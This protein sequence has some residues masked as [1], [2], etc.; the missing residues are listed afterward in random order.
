MLNAS[1]ESRRNHDRPLVFNVYPRRIYGVL[2]I[3]IVLLVAMS[4][5]AKL[6][7]LSFPAQEYGAV[8]ELCKRFYLDFENNVPAWF[9]TLGLFVASCLF[10]LVAY[11]QRA[12]K[13]AGLHWLGLSLLFVALA[14]D[15]ATYTHEIL[16]VALRNHLNLGGIFYFAW[17]VPGAIFVL[18][19][20]M[21]YLP[22]I[23]R[24]LPAVRNG[25][26][27]AGAFYVGGALGVELLG[28]YFAE[29]QGFDA[30]S[31]IVAMTCEESLEMLGI[32]TLIFVL[33]RYLARLCPLM[34]VQWAHTD[35]RSPS[36]SWSP[37]S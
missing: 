35:N 37:S 31:Y 27:L 5:V 25:L 24:L 36:V 11:V 16:I 29:S 18:L 26:L 3:M 8:N 30:A 4:M 21:V 19:V 34:H 1:S 10:G 20:A 7:M 28:G 22:F 13:D 6:V 17:V 14:V 12:R 23:V 15:E 33:L 2:L 9:S 32:A